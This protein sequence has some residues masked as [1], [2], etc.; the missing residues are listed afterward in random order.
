MSGEFVEPHSAHVSGGDART[1]G[2]LKGD[3]RPSPKNFRLKHTGTMG[4]NTLPT[5]ENYSYDCKHRKDPVPKITE[6]PVMGLR[7]N[8]N[9]IVTNAV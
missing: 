1:M 9:F 2:Y 3:R 5:V 4:D 7:S 8:K 6:K